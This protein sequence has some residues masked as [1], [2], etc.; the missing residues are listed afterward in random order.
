MAVEVSVPTGKTIT[1][2]VSGGFDSAV[3]WYSVYKICLERGQTC[4]PVTAPQTEFCVD[5]ADAIVAYVSSVLGG[6]ITKTNVVGTSGYDA[7]IEDSAAVVGRMYSVVETD[8]DTYGSDVFTAQSKT[9]DPTGSV[10]SYLIQRWGTAK[11]ESLILAN[12]PSITWHF[13]YSSLNKVDIMEHIKEIDSDVATEL[14]RLS[15]SCIKPSNNDVRRCGVC[16]SCIERHWACDET[17]TTDPGT[18]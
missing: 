1:V 18:K 10:E 6:S 14:L 13:P 11:L 7:E 17:G 8:P 3:L 5:D 2:A 9:Y 15:S 12:H 4:V 16:Y